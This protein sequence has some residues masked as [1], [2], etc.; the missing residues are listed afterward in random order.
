MNS[1]SILAHLLYSSFVS[2][3]D[4]IQNILEDVSTDRRSIPVDSKFSTSIA[5]CRQ[6]SV[7]SKHEALSSPGID[8]LIYINA[9][10]FLYAF[11]W[12]ITGITLSRTVLYD[13]SREPL[14]DGDVIYVPGMRYKGILLCYQ[15]LFLLPLNLWIW[16]LT[17]G[18]WCRV[19]VGR[20]RIK[21]H[22]QNLMETQ[23]L[24]WSICQ[25]A[26][27]WF[28]SIHDQLLVDRKNEAIHIAK[29]IRKW[30]MILSMLRMSVGVCILF[31]LI[32][33]IPAHSMGCF[34]R[35]RSCRQAFMFYLPKIIPYFVH[36]GIHMFALFKYKIF[37]GLFPLETL[38]TC[39]KTNW[40]LPRPH[41]PSLAIVTSLTIL[42]IYIFACIITRTLKTMKV[43]QNVSYIQHRS[44]HAFFQLFVFHNTIYFSSIIGFACLIRAAVPPKFGS[45]QSTRMVYTVT[46]ISSSSEE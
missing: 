36:Q 44:R 8:S 32:I 28:M 4:H 30:I 41:I 40:Y 37:C 24:L 5:T 20:C 2:N 14:G 17:L 6:T 43:M 42:E 7:S 23:L 3:T 31:M 45:P 46:L 26:G 9:A 39:L 34:Q 13:L 21:T 10:S 19:V 29:I 1:L 12:A 18:Y 33:W 22:D 16:I 38:L 27:F 11:A 35:L 15:G 25:P